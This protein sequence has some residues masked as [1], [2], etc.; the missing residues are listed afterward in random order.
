MQ[1]KAVVFSGVG[2]VELR[3]LPL[4][5]LAEG[6]LRIRTLC[7]GVS[8]GTEGW[9]LEDRFTWSRTRFPCV[10]GYQRVGIIEGVG[11][12]VDGWQVGARVFATRSAW[13]GPVVPAWGAHI[14]LADTT[15]EEVYR[16]EEGVSDANAAN[17]VVAQVGLNAASRLTFSEA[18]E[19]VLVMGDGLIGQSAAQA[20]RARGARV[21]LAGRRGLRL[22]L[23]GEYS[24]DAVI[25]SREE[26][27]A[28]A[29]RAITGTEKIRCVLDSVQ[30]ESA[31]AQYMPVLERRLGQIV[32]CGFTPGT[33]WADM[34]VLQQQELTAHFVSGWTRARIEATLD[35]MAAGRISLDNLITHRVSP[36][37]AAQMYALNREKSQDLLGIT[38]QW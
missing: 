7:S 32:Y 17:A 25:N 9:V 33:T 13:Q 10:P 35:R 28:G 20:A 38:F 11:A 18:G 36:D 16:V 4:P 15:A 22:R 23:A 19:W 29:V 14:A 21:I 5:E 1:N 24:A 3:D 30:T 34:A 31:Q 2:Q 8:G 6:H 27:L 37:R 12:G 26:D